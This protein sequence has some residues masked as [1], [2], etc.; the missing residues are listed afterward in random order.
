VFPLKDV[1]TMVRSANVARHLMPEIHVICYGSLNA[2][3]PYV[4]KCRALIDELGCGDNFEFG[5]FHPD[6]YGIF[7]E[8]DISVLSSISE[9]FPYTVLEAMSSGV[10]CV[11]T[12]VGGVREAVADT[13]IVVPPRD[14]ESLGQAL[15][16]LLSDNDRRREACRAARERVISEFTIKKQL[17]GYE[18][19]YFELHQ[20]SAQR[21]GSYGFRQ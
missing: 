15:V 11:A 5:G 16:E 18:A 8:G 9:G 19:L 20:A 7:I 3:P 4:E 13:G 14:P 2:D 1:E 6:P 21:Q 10:A 17:D 12:D